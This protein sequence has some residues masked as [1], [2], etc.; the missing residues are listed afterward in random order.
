M[1]QVTV[2][3]LVYD[4]EGVGSLRLD[5]FVESF[6]VSS[7]YENL[8]QT[9]TVTFPRKIGFK[10]KAIA[11]QKN[12]FF[13]RGQRVQ[14]YAGYDYQYDLIFEGYV[15]GVETDAPIQ[16]RCEDRMYLLKRGQITKSYTNV[17]LS[18]L[19]KDVI[20]STVK[21]EQT[22]SRST[23]LGKFRITKATPAQVLE[24]LRSTYGIYSFF[25]G[26]TLYIGT[27]FVDAIQKRHL[28]NFRVNVKTFDNLNYVREEDI[29]IKVTAVSIAPNNAK[30][31]VILGD[32]DG[33]NRNIFAY[34]L[35]EKDLRVYAQEKLNTLKYTGYEGSF[36][37]FGT[38][39][40]RHGDVAVLMDRLSPD[41]KGSYLVKSTQFTFSGDSGLTQS[42]ELE[43]KLSD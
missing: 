7:S 13:K 33:E 8:T 21:Y 36:D 25:H 22:L 23:S 39:Y 37:V 29:K 12:P 10:N 43:V 41:Q 2:K 4:V 6:D 18:N 27:P 20:P 1:K 5:N 24:E 28:F 38:P 40:V 30:T 19:L 9:M 15:V 32:P 17:S 34:D 14:L 11:S 42:I 35:S 3:L 31:E 26:D 16:L